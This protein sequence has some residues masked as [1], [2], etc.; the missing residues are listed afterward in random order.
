MKSKKIMKH[1]PKK[2]NGKRR[3]K[4][5][6]LGKRKYK[7][8]SPYQDQLHELLD[9]ENMIGAGNYAI[10]FMN[11]NTLNFDVRFTNL[12][13]NG[14][15]NVTSYV[16]DN[17]DFSFLSLIQQ[18]HTQPPSINRNNIEELFNSIDPI[19]FINSYM[20]N[21][22]NATMAKNSGELVLYR[23]LFLL[24]RERTSTNVYL[25]DHN[26]ISSEESIEFSNNHPLTN[27]ENVDTINKYMLNKYKIL[28]QQI[29]ESIPSISNLQLFYVLF[30][31]MTSGE[32]IMGFF[33]GF[34][35][36]VNEKI[37]ENIGPIRFSGSSEQKGMESSYITYIKNYQN[38]INELFQ[39]PK[40][41]YSPSN[42]GDNPSRTI[43]DYIYNLYDI[44]V[45][46]TN[47]ELLMSTYKVYYMDL[48]LNKPLTPTIPYV[49]L[50][51]AINRVDVNLSNYTMEETIEY[52]WTINTRTKELLQSIH[53][54]DS[55][56][57]MNA[58]QPIYTCGFKDAVCRR[59]GFQ[60]PYL[61]LSKRTEPTS[62]S[63]G[64]RRRSQRK[65]KKPKRT[66]TYKRRR[67]MK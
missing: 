49:L 12:D 37:A 63:K 44:Y 8:G 20:E 15:N 21:S 25:N 23:I 53:L 54:N 4:R 32:N 34:T 17:I 50:G 58:I 29:K 55:L 1:S 64:G 9:T 43:I 41:K 38:A 45:D 35:R 39:L 57:F 59:T 10:T 2:N 19:E 11:P 36:E 66:I 67:V 65:G 51:I 46:T 62:L 14:G 26:I 13:K 18:N 7:G 56:P 40:T 60:I 61:G 27:P 24:I 22:E 6:T 31:S 3:M 28:L 48:L 47:G 30:F 5:H 42:P 33:S 52:R 16:S